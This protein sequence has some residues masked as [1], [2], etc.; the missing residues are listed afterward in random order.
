MIIILIL[1]VLTVSAFFVYRA[2]TGSQ[3]KINNKTFK[4]ELALTDTRREKGL[5]GRD[6]LD[7]NSGMLFVFPKSD[8]QTFW[9]KDTK[10]PLDI[11][12]IE[13]A[14]IVEMTTLKPQSGTTIPQYTPKN[15]ANYVLEVN[16]GIT[17][18]NNIKVGDVV[19]IK[20]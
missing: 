17:S 16:A 9:M 2:K 20:Y 19:K 7:A 1:I 12:W 6:H 18:E 11:I 10:I 4:V 5:M 3:V 8:I 13:D 14:K 15:K